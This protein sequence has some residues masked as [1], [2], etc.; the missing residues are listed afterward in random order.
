MSVTVPS[1]VTTMPMEQCSSMTF[2]VPSSAAWVRGMG[3]GNHAVRTIRGSPSSV[4]PTAP[5]II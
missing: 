5:G 1:V 3:S 4:A 2:F